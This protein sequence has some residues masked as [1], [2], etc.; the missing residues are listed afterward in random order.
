MQTETS[1]QVFSS[2]MRE[3]YILPDRLN[4]SEYLTFLQ[5]VLTEMLSDVP[6]PIRQRIRFL[7]DGA[8][9]H[10]SI[11]VRAHLQATFPGDWIG[12]D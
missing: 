4:G 11:D 9:A 1:Q 6:M 7:H 2:R 3:T 8:P 5:E 10:F 12:R